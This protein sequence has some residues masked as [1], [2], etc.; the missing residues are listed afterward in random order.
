MGAFGMIGKN[1][2]IGWII[3]DEIWWGIR[4]KNE[5]S[6]YNFGTSANI[7]SFIIRN[8]EWQ[9]LW[10]TKICILLL[11]HSNYMIF[12]SNWSLGT[13]PDDFW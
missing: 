1:T 3:E 13:K 6:T 10:R 12:K 11:F 8:I 7:G 2:D 5:N 9:F 4:L